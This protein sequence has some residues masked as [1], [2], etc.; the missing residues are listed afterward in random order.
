MFKIN[1]VIT[2][3][4]AST[5]DDKLSG[6]PPFIYYIAFSQLCLKPSFL[7]STSEKNQVLLLKTLANLLA[8][9]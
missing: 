4:V 5:L 2:I 6:V 7:F 3:F 1:Q 9:Y 8:E